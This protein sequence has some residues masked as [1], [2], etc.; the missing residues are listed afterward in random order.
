MKYK[1]ATAPLEREAGHQQPMW[2]LCNE[3]CIILSDILCYASRPSKV[4]HLAFGMFL[5]VNVW[6]ALKLLNQ[7]CD[8]ALT[9]MIKSH[10][11]QLCCP[12]GFQY[13]YFT[14]WMFSSLIG[15]SQVMHVE[16]SLQLQFCKQL[17][18]F[19]FAPAALLR[20][21]YA[22]LMQQGRDFH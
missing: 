13:N 4:V 9:G 18:C 21:T 20:N 12:Q 10:L 16:L 17:A 7:L 14:S 3:S 2:G 15:H 11:K 8:S 1:A 6:I 22:V 19:S 5:L